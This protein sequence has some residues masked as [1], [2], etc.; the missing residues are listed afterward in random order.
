MAEI[1]EGK[2]AIG[3]SGFLVGEMYCQDGE[4]RE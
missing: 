4:S 3:D 1:P 2:R